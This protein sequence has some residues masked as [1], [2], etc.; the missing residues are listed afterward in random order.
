[1]Q[2]NK[3]YYICLAGLFLKL[4]LIISRTYL[5][6]NQPVDQIINNFR[7]DLAAGNKINLIRG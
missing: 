5:I 6:V 1:M 4:Y 2:E 3:Y 7:F